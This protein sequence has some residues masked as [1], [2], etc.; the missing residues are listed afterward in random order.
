MDEATYNF[1]E[2]SIQQLNAFFD[3]KITIVPKRAH[4]SPDS[5]LEIF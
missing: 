4:D 5:G 2:Y 1:K 3:V